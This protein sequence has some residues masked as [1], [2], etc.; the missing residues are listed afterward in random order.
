M[1][2]EFLHQIDQVSELISDPQATEILDD[3]ALICECF[4]VNV[5]DIRRLCSNVQKVDIDLLSATFEMGHG[6]RSC[7]NRKDYWVNRIF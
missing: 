1:D 4:C 2:K 5:G 7:L 3:E 6:C